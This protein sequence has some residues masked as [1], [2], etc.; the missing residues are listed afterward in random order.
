MVVTICCLCVFLFIGG[1]W[2]SE[3][4]RGYVVIYR[5]PHFVNK[6]T[7]TGDPGEGITNVL[8]YNAYM[9]R[10]VRV[11]LQEREMDGFR[12]IIVIKYVCL[13]LGVLSMFVLF[14]VVK[15]YR[16]KNKRYFKSSG[17][18]EDKLRL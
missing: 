15:R 14:R 12:D 1:L 16:A 11:V 6:I 17:K 3:A 8:N 18:Y 2:V 13:V 7:V 5:Y 9:Q 10:H 4:A